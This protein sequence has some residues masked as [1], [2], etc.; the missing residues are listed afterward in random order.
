MSR[1]VNRYAINYPN[2]LQY[3]QLFE[4]LLVK[5]KKLQNFPK[6]KLR[7][8]RFLA[9]SNTMASRRPARKKLISLFATQMQNKQINVYIE[10]LRHIFI[11]MTTIHF[12][13]HIRITTQSIFLSSI[14]YTENVNQNEKVSLLTD[15]FEI[16]HKN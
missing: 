1:L 4:F 8:H 9:E 2:N 10:F 11:L 15:I 5:K 14:A 3:L 12:N 6:D 13:L 16:A 7:S